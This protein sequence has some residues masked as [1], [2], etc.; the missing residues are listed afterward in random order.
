MSTVLVDELE[1]G[2]E[3]ELVLLL[4]CSEDLPEAFV[5]ELVDFAPMVV[6]TRIEENE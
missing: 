5:G 1:E 4:C 6:K 3:D 2:R